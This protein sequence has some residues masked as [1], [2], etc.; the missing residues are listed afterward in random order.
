MK[1]E[2]GSLF[3]VYPKGFYVHAKPRMRSAVGCVRYI[4]R[5]LARPAVAEYRI[6]SYDGQ[7]V[8]F[9]YIDHGTEKRV[10][11]IITAQVFIGRLMM[12]I[13]PKSFKMVRRYGI[14]SGSIQQKIKICFSLIKYIKSSYKAKQVTLKECYE[15]KDTPLSWR[16]RIIENF[17]RDPLKC[18]NCGEKMNLFEIWHPEYGY[19]FEYGK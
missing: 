15:I 1:I 19:L 9:W 8:H 11:E 6:E 10:D 12:H 2:H 7:M 3:K 4:G 5:Y 14:Y 17:S 13:P 16:E 18:K